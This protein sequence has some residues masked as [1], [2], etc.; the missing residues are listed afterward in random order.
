MTRDSWNVWTTDG[1]VVLPVD[2]TKRDSLKLM[3]NC[4]AMRLGPLP[5]SGTDRSQPIVLLSELQ[6]RK[7]TAD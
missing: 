2:S 3:D 4:Y 1:T 7:Q 6:L 5:T